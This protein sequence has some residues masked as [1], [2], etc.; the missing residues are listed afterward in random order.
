MKVSN[1]LQ[2][3]SKSAFYLFL[4]VLGITMWSGQC[5]ETPYI[6][7]NHLGLTG[8]CQPGVYPRLV[9]CPNEMETARSRIN[10]WPYAYFLEQALETAAI[11]PPAQVSTYDKLKEQD[12]ANIAKCNAVVAFFNNSTSHAEKSIQLL[13]DLRS[14]WTFQFFPEDTSDA[15]I[16]IAGTLVNGLAAFD[17]LMAGGFLTA[18]DQTLI[19]SSLGNIAQKL[20]ETWI[21]GD[22]AFVV[23]MCQN[24]YNTKL[25]T[26]LGIAALML[27]NNEHKKEWLN[28]AT[29]EMNR[30]YGDG[31]TDIN[32]YLSEE[33]VCNESPH[34]FH[35][36]QLFAL[37]FGILYQYMVGDG[38]TYQDDCHVAFDGCARKS[39]P[40]QNILYTER[41]EKAYEWMVKIQ[42]PGGVRPPLDEGRVCILSQAPLWQYINGNNLMAWDFLQ[43]NEYNQ[44]KLD[45]EGHFEYLSMKVY[46]INL[47]AEYS[48][49]VDF[50][51]LPQSIDIGN[52]QIY[53]DSGMVIFRNHW[54]L[55]AIYAAVLGESGIMR[56]Q[57]HNHADATSFMLYA[58]EEMLAMETGY[59]QIPEDSA[60]VARLK[61]S[62]HEAHNVILVDGEGAPPAG[63]NYPGGVDAAMN[64]SLDTDGVDYT[65]V[66][67]SYQNVDFLRSVLFANERYLVVRDKIEAQSSHTYS[68][69]LHGY[70][71][72][73]VQAGVFEAGTFTQGLDYAIWERPKA[74]LLA[75]LD[76]TQGTP[77]YT[78][79]LWEHAW[80]SGERGLHRYIDGNITTTSGHPDLSYLAVVFPQK[81]AYSFPII[82]IQ[83]AGN[84]IACITITGEG[85][86]DI[87]LSQEMENSITVDISGFHTIETDGIFVWIALSPDGTVDKAFIKGGSKLSYDG[88]TLI[89]LESGEEVSVYQGDL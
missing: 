88:E 25:S 81:T 33:G 12:R 34:Y 5:I 20:Y 86:K 51:N 37:H 74:K 52:T 15:F 8:N 43:T 31:S 50:I 23:Q 62:K 17:L 18:S 10:L 32:I 54:G 14:D 24:N 76:S 67:T 75:V 69:R 61:T 82:E 41:F 70:G 87:S 78:N 26:S 79:D 29:T 57:V 83:D 64:Q 46:H 56:S 27:D 84:E 1:R 55:D 35:F 42:L 47:A 66:S 58:F 68:W 49:R 39:I 89:L 4:M 72:G 9:M 30:F 40:F 16:R 65:E 48:A 21:T 28:F 3:I 38:G 19:E 63:I 73:E 77:T 11:E 6:N 85:F 71:G 45:A 36:G 2:G 7:N 80:V 53:E 60:N 59:Y 22:G 44:D 13:K